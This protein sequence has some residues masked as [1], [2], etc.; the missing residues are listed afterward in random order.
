MGIGDMLQLVGGQFPLQD[1]RNA[2]NH[3][4]DRIDALAGPITFDGETKNFESLAQLASVDF[5]GGAGTTVNVVQVAGIGELWYSATEPAHAGK[6][7][8]ADS[9]W[10]EIAP[11]SGL[12]IKQ[13]G[14]RG[15]G[16]TNDT[17]AI[18]NTI[19]A[20]VALGRPEI[21]FPPGTFLVDDGVLSS[22]SARPGLTFRGAGRENTIL[23]LADD[24]SSTR[25]FY[26]SGTTAHADRD[27]YLGIR[28]KGQNNRRANG[29]YAYDSG[30]G[31][32]KRNT[33]I[34]CFFDNLSVVI[35]TA[36]TTNADEWTF[37]AC[38][39]GSGPT[40]AVRTVLKTGNPQSMVHKFT[41]CEVYAVGDVFVVMAG[42]EI[43]WKDGSIIHEP[44]SDAWWVK[45]AGDSVTGYQVGNFIFS[46]LRCEARGQHAKL[47]NIVPTTANAQTRNRRV[48]FE[49]CNLSTANLGTGILRSNAIL[50]GNGTNVLFRDCIMPALRPA[51]RG[52][53]PPP[54]PQARLPGPAPGATATRVTGS[55]ASRTR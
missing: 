51:A 16:T 24:G 38:E 26:H 8:S 6:V 1:T 12:S 36:G 33:F 28:F 53:A 7:Q 40:T 22:G 48:L 19:A 44:T 29:F 25:H 35:E 3:L 17:T 11:V 21:Y 18:E 23:L 55:S 30:A 4:D 47:V 54:G 31:V 42:G 14:A 45:F 41:D 15:D 27:T 37:I 32:E 46:H 10:W 2:L 49:H 20:S 39:F 13:F 43:H 52:R 50:I 9:A 34:D 5:E